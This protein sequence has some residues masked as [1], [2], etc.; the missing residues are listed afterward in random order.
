MMALSMDQAEAEMPRRRRVPGVTGGRGGIRRWSDRLLPRRRTL[1]VGGGYL[2]QIAA[3]VTYYY[4]CRTA[5]PDF[6]D[7]KG[8]V[9]GHFG[10]ADAFILAQGCQGLEAELRNRR[11]R[12][13]VRKIHRCRHAF[14]NDTNRLG[15]H[16]ATAALRSWE[17]SVGSCAPRWQSPIQT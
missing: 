10:T 5:K 14:F 8:P 15:T 3:A 7:I 6:R 13:H 17:R 12:R 16:D 4:S 1:P 2:P 9:L 11:R